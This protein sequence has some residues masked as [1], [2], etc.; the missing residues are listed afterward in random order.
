MKQSTVIQMLHVFIDKTEIQSDIMDQFVNGKRLGLYTKYFL[1]KFFYIYT[2]M[3]PTT[4]QTSSGIPRLFISEMHKTLRVNI[5]LR[6]SHKLY[7]TPLN[8][9]DCGSK[10]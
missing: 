3:N 8:M 7:C 1:Q 4:I 9:A 6:Q 2:T 10:F 5:T